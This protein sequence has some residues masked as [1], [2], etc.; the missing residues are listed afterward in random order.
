[1]SLAEEDLLHE[2]KGEEMT[3]RKNYAGALIISDI[4]G[5]E[6]IERVYIGFTKREAMRRFRKE[7]KEKRG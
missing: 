2:C 6:Y 7:I 1:V 5:N 3:V 4:I